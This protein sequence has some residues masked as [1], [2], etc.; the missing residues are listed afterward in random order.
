MVHL[1]VRC[2]RHRLDKAHA[3]RV[4]KVDS[5]GAEK[6]PLSGRKRPRIRDSAFSRSF[7]DPRHGRPAFPEGSA[8]RGSAPAPVGREGKGKGRATGWTAGSD[9]PRARRLKL[10]GLADPGSVRPTRAHPMTRAARLTAKHGGRGARLETGGRPPRALG[11][12]QP[13]QA[14]NPRDTALAR[15]GPGAASC[16]T[17]DASGRAPR[18]QDAFSI[19]L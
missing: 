3:T 7:A 15:G 17:S 18:G 13:T 16:P 9:A 8:G 14:E 10:L 11:R 2:G 12:R 6:F 4:A 19:I 5:E 1:L